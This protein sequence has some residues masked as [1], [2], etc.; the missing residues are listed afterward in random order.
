[1]DAPVDADVVLALKVGDAGQQD[2]GVVLGCA[3]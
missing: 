2:F 1:L 3:G